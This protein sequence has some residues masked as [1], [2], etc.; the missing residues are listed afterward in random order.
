MNKKKKSNKSADLVDIPAYGRFCDI[1]YDNEEYVW[2]S[3]GLVIRHLRD[4]ANMDQ[5]VF[6]RLI[7]GYT[8]GQI[9][10]YET[11]QTEPPIAFWEK[12]ACTFGLNLTWAITGIGKPYILEYRDSKERK[13]LEQWLIL[14]TDKDNFLKELKG[15]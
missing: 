6:G 7:Q 2:Q 5:E 3:W 8:R 10:R 4:F 14:L 15:W 11:E 13:R 12:M 1:N 9:G